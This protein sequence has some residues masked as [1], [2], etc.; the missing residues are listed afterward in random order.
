MKSK[1]LIDYI[2]DYLQSVMTYVYIGS[3]MHLFGSDMTKSFINK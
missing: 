2:N 1:N 3:R